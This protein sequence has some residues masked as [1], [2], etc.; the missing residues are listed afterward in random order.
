MN[1]FWAR[2]I[3]GLSMVFIL[4]VALYAGIWSVFA[5]FFIVNA[6]ALVEYFR[7]TSTGN[8]FPQGICGTAAGI[9]VYT[10]VSLIRI[11]WTGWGWSFQAS[12]LIPLFFLPF[13]IEIF[14]KKPNP[15]VN[16]SLT[17]TGLIYVSVPL[18]LLNL[19][20]QEATSFFLGFPAWLTGYFIL[21]W[22]YDTGAYLYG[23]QFG[24]HKFFER[25][26]PRKTWEGTI[27]GTVAAVAGAVVL[28]YL[29]RDIR[30]ADWLALTGI[31]LVFGTFGDLA[32]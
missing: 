24:K 3:T 20:N 27:A 17:V 31:I 9:L 28:F 23:K 7:L 25:I 22:I 15:L 10:G 30:L 1:N 19:M 14:R 2:T 5:F 12:L 11:P 4:L 18:A 6:I 32:E 21:T 13:I 16:I 29:V 8:S 26:S